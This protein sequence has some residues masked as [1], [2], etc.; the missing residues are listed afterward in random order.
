ML[1]VDAAKSLGKQ[2]G[3]S[4]SFT[5][6]IPENTATRVVVREASKKTKVDLKV[7]NK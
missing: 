7:T 3:K 1:G 4:G 6:E 5:A 2:K